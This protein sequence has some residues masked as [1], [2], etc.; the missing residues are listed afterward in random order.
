MPSQTFF[1]LPEEKRGTITKIA[2]DEFTI[3]NYNS[4]SI[5]RI[6][7]AANIAKGSFYQYFKDKKDLYLYLLDLLSKTKS[8]F[9]Q[10]SSLPKSKLDF[11]EYL[12]WLLETSI[13][14]DLTYPSLSQL[15]YRAFYGNLP[16]QDHKIEEA[17]AE[18]S[19]FIR[20]MIIKGVEDGDIDPTI[21][22]DLA[23]FVVH[24]L[25]NSFSHYAT[26]RIGVTPDK[27]V[28][29][30][31]SALDPELVKKM[32]NQ[33]IRILKLGLVNPN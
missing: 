3:H 11:F 28:Q 14:F 7:K 15:S 33:L 21:D 24:T 16:F 25:S 20:Q 2:L 5:S 32:F 31:S 26:K 13:T 9:F 1:N 12:S 23:V 22:L 8:S 6:V 10:E 17:K 30:G 4:A 27:L 29:E 19:V 18:F